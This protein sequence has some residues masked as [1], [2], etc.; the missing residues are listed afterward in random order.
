VAAKKKGSRKGRSLEKLIESLE[1]VLG[2]KEGVT[3]ESPKFLADRVTGKMREHD[4]VITSRTAHH[5]TIIAIECRDRSRKVGVNDMESFASKC[6]DTRVNKC[7]M[8]SPKGFTKTAQQKAKNAG[9]T[10]LSL[11]QV[12]SFDWMIA[13]G[14]SVRNRTIRS[15]AWNLLT[16]PKLAKSP[17]AFTLIDAN[18]SVMTNDGLLSAIKNELNELKDEGPNVGTHHVRFSFNNP[19]LTLRD[20]ES[21]TSYVVSTAIATVEYHVTEELIPFNLVTYEDT[22]TGAT[23]TNAAVADLKVGSFSGKLMIVHKGDEGGHFVF[24][25]DKPEMD[26][27]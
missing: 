3:I 25:P 13:P 15:A 22:E 20:D 21:G 17:A 24:V 1:R 27:G 9:I 10:C 16:E 6:Q 12:D 14:I 26:R 5:E 4:V 7:V 11:R 23:I 18:G 2:G 19:G 8:V